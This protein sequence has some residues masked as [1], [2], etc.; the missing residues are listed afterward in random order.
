MI[1][2]NLKKDSL[3]IQLQDFK[4]KFAHIIIIFCSAR[5]G[6]QGLARTRQALYH[7]LHP[8]PLLTF[9]NPKY[10]NYCFME[11]WVLL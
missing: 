6:T 8:Q 2:K 5:D 3:A 7:E 4:M 11:K 9:M 1:E 10:K